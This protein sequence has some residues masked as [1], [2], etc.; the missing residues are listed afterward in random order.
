MIERSLVLLKPDAVQRG[1]MGKI[2]CRFEDAGLKAVGVKMV[3]VKTEF[4]Q[5]HYAAHLEK[6]FYPGLEKMITEGPVLALV[7]EGLHAV[8]TVR[9]MVGPTEPKTAA[10]GTIRGDFAHHSYEY[11]DK[12]GIAI[13]N[14]I[15]AS[16]NIAEAKEE[17][18]LW[19]EDKELHT[20]ETVHEKHVF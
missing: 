20:Y 3:W 15:H 11:T 10:P 16:G 6:S 9:K 5:K 7:L 18:K 12:K 14:L 17:I 2:I 1:L 8:E 4:A 13:K 19:F